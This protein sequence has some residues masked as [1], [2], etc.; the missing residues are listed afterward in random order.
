MANL[1]LSRKVKEGTGRAWA[2]MLKEELRSNPTWG[3]TCQ[4]DTITQTKLARQ[5]MQR[6]AHYSLLQG[7]IAV[8]ATL[9]EIRLN[10]EILL[11]E[12]CVCAFFFLWRKLHSLRKITRMNSTYG[13]ASR[14]RSTV[15]VDSSTVCC[16][17]SIQTVR[18]GRI[19]RGNQ[20]EENI[21][22][23]YEIGRNRDRVD[24][25]VLIRRVGH[26]ID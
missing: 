22:K 11:S 1:D 9:R 10:G 15:D 5:G 3:H 18:E 20:V 12:K 24:H 23:M 19:L 14:L 2:E 13:H 8:H 4:I 16:Y 17:E 25:T 26:G 6:T 7:C 21:W